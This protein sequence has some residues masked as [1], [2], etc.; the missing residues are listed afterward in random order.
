LTAN[1]EKDKK[2]KKSFFK[3]LCYCRSLLDS[4]CDYGFN[5]CP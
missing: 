5:T 4:T 2:K 3:V 1:N